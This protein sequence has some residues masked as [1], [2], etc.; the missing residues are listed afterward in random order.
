MPSL[1]SSAKDALAH[2]K[3]KKPMG[4]WGVEVTGVE[5]SPTYRLLRRSVPLTDNK[6]LDIHYDPLSD[7]VVGITSKSTR[8]TNTSQAQILVDKDGNPVS[9]GQLKSIRSYNPSKSQ[10]SSA[11]STTGTTATRSTATA[12]RTNNNI[13][14]N[15]APPIFENMDNQQLLQYGLI[16]I[17]ACLIYSIISQAV[18]MLS[19]LLFPCIF[20][21]GIQTCPSEQSFDAKKELKRV[22][23]GHHLPEDHPNKPKN[24]FDKTIAKISATVTTELA[25]GL[26][27][28]VSMM[29]LAG[30]AWFTSVKVP[31]AQLEGYWLGAFGK[32]TYIG[33]RSLENSNQ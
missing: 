26:G 17:M 11:S 24:F 29:S 27:Y 21:Y 32:W 15:A 6:F 20:L 28:E 4:G 23:R 10:S 30:A 7:C 1:S 3:R 2:L 22:L 13:G 9:K 14:I 33:S 8:L 31:A 12:I 25:T 16:F 5:G 19:L 18:Y